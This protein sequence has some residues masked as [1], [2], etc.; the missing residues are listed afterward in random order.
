MG[1]A[2]LWPLLEPAQS[3]ITLTALS[4]TKFNGPHRGFRIGIDASIW[5]FHAEYGKE[6]EN[7]QLRTLFFRCAELTNHGF[8]PLFV[9]DGPLRPKFKR[10]KRVNTTQQNALV[11]G[12]QAIIEAFGFEYRQAPGEAEAEL[13]FLNRIGVIDGIL[14][15]D[16]DTFL[17]GANTVIRNHSSTHPSAAGSGSVEKSTVVVYNLPHPAFPDLEPADLIFIA[18]CSG[19]DYDTTGI[20]SCGVKIA[21][22]LAQA[23]FSKSLYH[24]ATT[25]GHDRARMEEFL[26]GWRAD[27]A[28]ELR[29]NASGCLPMK[30]PSV[31]NNIP[32]TFPDMDILLSYVTPI[33]SESKDR[34]DR[35]DSLMTGHGRSDGW[36]QKDPSLP[37]LAR[38]CEQY[39]EWG[40]KDIIIKRFRTVIFRGVVLR[41]LRRAILLQDHD[42]R[43]VLPAVSHDLLKKYFA[44]NHIVDLNTDGEPR[45]I[46][47]NKIHSTR[48]HDSTS[49]T[50]EYRL[51]VS[52]TVLVK[53]TASGVVGDR[54]PPDEDE[55]AYLEGDSGGSDVEAGAKKKRN[56]KPQD[57]YEAL[58]LWIP[59]DLVAHAIPNILEEYEEV[60]RKKAEKKAGKGKKATEEKLPAKAKKAKAKDANVAEVPCSPTKKKKA[61]K[62]NVLATA[63][64]QLKPAQPKVDARTR[65][66]AM[67]EGRVLTD[68]ETESEEDMWMGPKDYLAKRRSNIPWEDDTIDP[69]FPTASAFDERPRAKGTDSP[70]VKDPTEPIVKDLTKGRSFI[71]GQNKTTTTKSKKAPSTSIGMNRLETIFNS[72]KPGT[73]SAA[74]KKNKAKAKAAP[75][76]T[77]SGLTR[78]LYDDDTFEESISL[79]STS[80]V[81]DAYAGKAQPSI[82]TSTSTSTML[83]PGKPRPFPMPSPP[84][85]DPFIDNFHAEPGPPDTPSPK[86]ANSRK[87]SDLSSSSE[88]DLGGSPAKS[89]ERDLNKSPRKSKEHS[90]PRKVSPVEN[91]RKTIA[92]VQHPSR[93][94]RRASS[95]TPTTRSSNLV[96]TGPKAIPKSKTVLPVINISS[97]EDDNGDSEMECDFMARIRKSAARIGTTSQS[98]SQPLKIMDII[99]LT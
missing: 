23:G 69:G 27:I 65:A 82:S 36:I 68:S 25:M 78:D 83:T 67:F 19:G 31:A 76:T 42:A 52:P 48:T 80:R 7:P 12:M 5:F 72:R 29:T 2:G 15:D 60:L 89:G 50:L 40:I 66:I 64:T 6:G 32:S 98:K 93:M 34:L 92:D 51:E 58:R 54:R 88:D 22:G 37:K 30:K 56:P 55:W 28:K 46:L 97:S 13:A 61:A 39:F 81:L 73:I 45:P 95:P 21:Y 17:F 43:N 8:L 79:P 3:I 96:K 16:V 84:R 85:D 4:L 1:V 94:P 11:T 70:V 10:G 62:E 49:N 38:L 75:V 57:P 99:D 86:K 9:F 90:S 35:Y 59:G 63:K 33:T 77:Y 53:L 24:A 74:V 71:A 20:P 41:I 26:H 91:V 87:N 14:S 18:L 44:P 47:I